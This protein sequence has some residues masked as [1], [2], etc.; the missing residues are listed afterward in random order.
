MAYIRLLK[1]LDLLLEY[2][3][4][5]EHSLPKETLKSEKFRVR[6][7]RSPYVHFDVLLLFL[8]SE[9]TPQVSFDGDMCI[10]LSLLPGKHYCSE[11]K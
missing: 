1:S 10:D 7:S 6:P 2:F 4:N 5:D 3:N 8:V 9:E 11:Q